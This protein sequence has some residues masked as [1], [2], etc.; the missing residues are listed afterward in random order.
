MSVELVTILI[1]ALGNDQCMQTAIEGLGRFGD[2]RAL[3]SLAVIEQFHPAGIGKGHRLW[4]YRRYSARQ[5]MNDILGRA[6]KPVAE[7]PREHYERDEPLSYNELCAMAVCP[8]PGIR[9]T[10]IYRLAYHPGD[11]TVLFLLERIGQEKH[12]AVLERIGQTLRRCMVVGEDRSQLSVSAEMM[13]KAFDAFLATEAIPMLSAKYVNVENPADYL[14]RTERK[15]LAAY[16]SGAKGVVYAANKYEIRLKRTRRFHNL[17]SIWGV[18]SK[19]EKLRIASYGAVTAIARLSPKTGYTWLQ[20]EREQ[21]QKRLAPL[22]DSPT[23][24]IRLIECLGN[25]GDKRLTPR[26][27]ELLGHDDQIVR[28]FSTYAL[29]RIGDPAALPALKHLAQTDPHQ[30]ENGTYGVRKAATRTIEKIQE[31]IEATSAT[32]PPVKWGEPVEGVQVRL[33]PLRDQAVWPHDKPPKLSADVYYLEGS[34]ARVARRQ[35]R[36]R[37]IFD[38]QWYEQRWDQVRLFR[39]GD[40]GGG[41]PY[42]HTV[43]SLKGDWHAE[44]G[45]GLLRL[46]PGKHT[47]CVAFEAIVKGS[48]RAFTVVSNPVEIEIQPSTQTH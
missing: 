43:F 46:T 5:A 11:D 38:G 42:D 40:R 4:Y 24:N 20:Y 41:T 2:E 48:Q 31:T 33:R 9:N 25:I 44:K 29:G 37:I 36:G 13:Q 10:A 27:I 6:G 47:L 32:Q 45:G 30:Y 17:V 12:P 34:K 22:L 23:P 3:E 21:L 39:G 28:T 19:D 26:L 8:N 1:T 7:V 14:T 16:I 18:S 35:E 15:L